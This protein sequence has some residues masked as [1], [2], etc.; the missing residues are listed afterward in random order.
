MLNQPEF[1]PNIQSEKPLSEP[2]FTSTEPVV[3]P[4]IEEEVQIGSR[5]IETGRVLVSKSVQ[6]S[7]EKIDLPQ[8]HEETDV[9][10]VPVNQYVD[11]TPVVRYEGDTMII[12]VL[13]EEVIVQKRLVLVEEVRITKRQIYSRRAEEVTL[14]KEV[15]SVDRLPSPS[16]P[17]NSSS[18]L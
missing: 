8:M 13:R 2:A 18:E 16:S 12:P 3:I 5:V 10:R 7:V 15:L 4:V 14:R 1:Y 6:E 17:T 9:Q 11:T